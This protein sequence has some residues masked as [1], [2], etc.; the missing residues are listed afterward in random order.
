MIFFVACFVII[1]YVLFDA[2]I[3]AFAI[4]CM[5]I[6][7]LRSPGIVYGEVAELFHSGA[8]A[9]AVVLASAGFGFAAFGESPTFS[10]GIYSRL[11]SL[12]RNNTIAPSSRVGLYAYANK[13]IKTTRH[14]VF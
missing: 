4:N 3:A 11:Y 5:V 2:L 7:T 9:A 10:T 1:Y 14:V 6:G 13:K 8:S 12:F